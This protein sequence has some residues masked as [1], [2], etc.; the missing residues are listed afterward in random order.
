MLEPSAV[1]ANVSD[2]GLDLSGPVARAGGRAKGAERA[3][4]EAA[5]CTDSRRRW[6]TWMQEF[7]APWVASFLTHA[8]LL[9]VLGMIIVG[10]RSEAPGWL[11]GSIRAAEIPL[12]AVEP[13]PRQGNPAGENL[14]LALKRAR[15]VLGETK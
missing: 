12:D 4:S 9:V 13:L 2:A 10:E 1:V 6:R 7:L 8:V 5:N 15:E 3:E 11:E 14:D